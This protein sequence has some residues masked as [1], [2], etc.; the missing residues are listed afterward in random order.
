MSEIP[1]IMYCTSVEGDHRDG[2]SNIL[3][4]TSVEGDHRDGDSN[5]LQTRL[6]FG[7]DR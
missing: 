5:I 3:Q 7:G 4:C 6:S 1:T 2:D